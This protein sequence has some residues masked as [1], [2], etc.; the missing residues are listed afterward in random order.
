MALYGIML[1]SIFTI[2]GLDKFRQFVGKAS[3]LPLIIF[4]CVYH[5]IYTT[6]KLY[7][8]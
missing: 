8:R 5:L 3:P 1:P 4:E 6:K 7:N 2:I